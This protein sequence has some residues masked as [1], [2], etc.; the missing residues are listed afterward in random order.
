MALNLEGFGNLDE[1]NQAN[2]K[3][4]KT[5]LVTS[6]SILQIKL[7]DIEE[8]SEQPR[9][10]DNEASE[11]LK[12][13]AENIKMY[14]VKQPIQV[15]SNGDKYQII[16][17]HRRFRASQLAGKESIPGILDNGIADKTTL[18]S[19]QLTENIHREDLKPYEVALSMQ[20][21]INNGLKQK[22]I[23]KLLNKSKNYVY[24]HLKLLD[25]PSFILEKHTSG[26]C[27]SLRTTL[28]LA[29]LY[30]KNP[31]VVENFLSD[32]DFLENGEITRTNVEL[33]K[34]PQHDPVIL[35]DQLQSENLEEVTS[36]EAPHE[37]SIDDFIESA[38][39][40]AQNI[41]E[42]AS[43]DDEIEAPASFDFEEKE[44][45]FKKPTFKISHNGNDARIMMKKIPN[46]YGKIFIKLDYDGSIEEVDIDKVSFL[47]LCESD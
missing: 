26:E 20:E 35:E 46:E 25:V 13:L 11:S 36:I 24:E 17:G 2:E 42:L 38:N 43:F 34:K 4:S 28:D 8:D 27:P 47:E 10:M 14:G 41:E 3:Q 37:A 18:I 44:K 33:L 21:L 40:N 39:S 45:T 23:V 5:N 15:K 32:Y 31:I 22:D 7:S 30:S 19:L 29:R 6:N 12:E 1:M 9:K 16:T